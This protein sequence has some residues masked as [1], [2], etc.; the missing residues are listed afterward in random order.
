M[1]STHQADAQTSHMTREKEII[2][3]R[4]SL[5]AKVPGLCVLGAL[6]ATFLLSPLGAFAGCGNQQQQAAPVASIK[7]VEAF[8]QCSTRPLS[9]TAATKFA[10]EGW[11]TGA[12]DVPKAT[13]K[14]ATA[15]DPAP[16]PAPA[17]AL[18]PEQIK[19]LSF[20]VGNA[21]CSFAT[22]DPGTKA[23]LAN[24]DI[25]LAQISTKGKPNQPVFG[26]IVGGK[27]VLFTADQNGTHFA[28]LQQGARVTLGNAVIGKA[29]LPAPAPS[30]N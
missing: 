10:S 8:S 18:T 9:T 2:M 28:N 3:K 21:S 23:T 19:S 14:Q 20:L 26:M 17:P 5:T 11:G 1:F 27:V 6:G 12:N 7:S 16:A 4:V 22:V 29:P 15:G 24:G 13:V 30:G 25:F